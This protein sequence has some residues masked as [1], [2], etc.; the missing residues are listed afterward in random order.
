MTELKRALWKYDDSLQNK[1]TNIEEQTVFQEELVHIKARRDGK[2][3][4]DSD[5]KISED[6]SP[7]QN[8]VGLAFS[9]GGIRSATFGLGVLEALKNQNLLQKIDY[10]STVS[11]G[12]Y[13]GAWL[14]ANCKRA[15][16]CDIRVCL[17]NNENKKNERIFF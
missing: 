10:L 1:Q 2:Y 7:Q 3:L 4:S 11:G 12:G 9:G 8:L 17:T 14:S 16:D 13:I 15:T 5:A 6:T